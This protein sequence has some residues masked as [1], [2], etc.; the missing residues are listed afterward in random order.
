MPAGELMAII[1]G[2]G[3]GK[4]RDLI[5][6][7]FSLDLNAQCHGPSNVR[8]FVRYKWRDYITAIPI[9][10]V[11]HAYVMQQDVL[12]PTLTVRDTLQLPLPASTTHEE[13]V[14]TVEELVKSLKHLARMGRTIVT[15]IH[16]PRFEIWGLI[17]RVTL[18][19]RAWREDYRAKTGDTIAYGVAEG[20]GGTPQAAN[21]ATQVQGLEFT[22]DPMGI[23]G[24]FFEAVTMGIISGW[25]FYNLDGSLA[26]IRSKQAAFFVAA[27]LSGYLVLLYEIYRLT[28]LDIKGLT[29]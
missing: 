12:I 10:T 15:T 1:S 8:W 25:I 14:E 4:T 18:L 29:H 24:S 9:K 26:G 28:N 20:V 3:S 22:Q 21:N 7:T 27:S 19:S 13:R 17:D 5:I 16:Q 11:G 6:Y 2:S 23:F